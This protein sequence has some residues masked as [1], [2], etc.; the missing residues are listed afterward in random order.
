MLRYFL[1]LHIFLTF[2]FLGFSHRLYN[3]GVVHFRLFILADTVMWVNIVLLHFVKL[4][5][6]FYNRFL[7]KVNISI[8]VSLHSQTRN[9]PI[10]K[11]LENP[12]EFWILVFPRFILSSSMRACVNY[13]RIFG[14]FLLLNSYSFRASIYRLRFSPS[15]IWKLLAFS[16]AIPKLLKLGFSLNE[17]SMIFIDLLSHLVIGQFMTRFL[18]TVVHISNFR[19]VGY[20][21]GWGF[22][23]NSFEFMFASSLLLRFFDGVLDL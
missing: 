4:D 21:F 19:K 14:W 1:S 3:S 12:L 18:E 7:Q 15:T 16:F 20:V 9:R 17:L 6:S 22:C 11:T 2:F 5:F 10:H 8:E 13:Q 23:V